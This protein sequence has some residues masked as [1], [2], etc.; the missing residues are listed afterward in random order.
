MRT[1]Q[2]PVIQT[3]PVQSVICVPSDRAT[4]SG[5]TDFVHVKGVAY[6]GAGRGITRVELSIDGG[7]TFTAAE[8]L[9]MPVQLD[10]PAPESGMG[11][12]WA[13]QRFEQ[14]GVLLAPPTPVPCPRAA[15]LAHPTGCCAW[16]KLPLPEDVRARLKA[17]E[18]VSIEVVSKAIDGDFNSQPQDVKHIW[19]VLGICVNHWCRVKGPRQSV[20]HRVGRGNSFGL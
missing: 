8:L 17:G 3:L 7:S 1:D 2:G 19:N 14:V 11:R 13:W 10:G 16:Q 20:R 5:N 9:P 12:N 4:L 6:S 18:K 15:T